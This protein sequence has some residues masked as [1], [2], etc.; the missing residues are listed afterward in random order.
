MVLIRDLLK[1]KF[2]VF[3]KP[4]ACHYLSFVTI[5]TTYNN[6]RLHRSVFQFF[7]VR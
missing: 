6:V 5:Y 1:Q 4:V 3:Y 2:C 7:G